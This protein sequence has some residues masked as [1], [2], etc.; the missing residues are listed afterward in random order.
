[1]LIWLAWASSTSGVETKVLNLC[2]SFHKATD[3]N[4]LLVPHCVEKNVI[5]ALG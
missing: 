5:V 4:G 1:M 2:E 3:A